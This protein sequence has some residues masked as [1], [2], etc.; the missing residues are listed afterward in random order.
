LGV[1]V[2]V[3][4]A[5]RDALDVFPFERPDDG[6][7]LLEREREDNGAVG[8]HTLADLQPAPPPDQGLGF[9][10]KPEVVEVEAALTRDL[11]HVAEAARQ[12]RRSE[13]HTSELQSRV[14]LVCRLLLEKKKRHTDSQQGSTMLAS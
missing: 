14:D 6:G 4:Q 3:K 10:G 9:R 12:S 7:H 8:A 5:D 11:E 13:E 2:A 1:C